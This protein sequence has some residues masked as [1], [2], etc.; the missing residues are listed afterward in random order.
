MARPAEKFTD[1]DGAG[2]LGFGSGLRELL[3]GRHPP[4]GGPLDRFDMRG[5]L[6]FYVMGTLLTLP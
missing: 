3:R 6:L 4:G 2:V 5:L 1:E